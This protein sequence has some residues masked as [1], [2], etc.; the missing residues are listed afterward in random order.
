M[1]PS[2]KK[3]RDFKSWFGRYIIRSYGKK[4]PD[5]TWSCAV[6]HAHAVKTVFDD[7]VDDAVSTERWERKQSKKA[8]MKNIASIEK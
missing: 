1:N 2:V 7:L 4:C 6:C 8:N 5:F 3:L